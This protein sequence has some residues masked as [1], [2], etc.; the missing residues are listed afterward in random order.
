M[1]DNEAKNGIKYQ[2]N[3]GKKS[4]KI[5]ENNSETSENIFLNIL[6]LDRLVLIIY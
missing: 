3:G 2:K 4:P 6:F 5:P 1:F